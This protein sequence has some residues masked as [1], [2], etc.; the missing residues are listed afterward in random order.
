MRYAL[1]AGALALVVALTGCDKKTD[2]AAPSA[3]SGK[4]AA[5][6]KP[7]PPPKVD[8][9]TPEKAIYSFQE[10]KNW[11]M[12]ETARRITEISLANQ[13]KY[14]AVYNDV[15]KICLSS[16]SSRAL[17]IL[18]DDHRKSV[19]ESRRGP[20]HRYDFVITELK[21]ETDSRVIAFLT[22]K[23]STPV[24]GGV[25]LDEASQKLREKGWKYKID[26]ELDNGRWLIAQISDLSLYPE[27]WQPKIIPT[28]K[29]GFYDYTF[30]SLP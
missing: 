2:A 29:G 28:A 4:D 18:S 5:I 26:L 25:T 7:I 27:Q 6:A 10:I 16:F 17:Q 1:F 21:K 19:E 20:V 30:V 8:L 15:G 3:S 14:E 24:E 12:A 22:V 23:N 13:K 11:E 9:S